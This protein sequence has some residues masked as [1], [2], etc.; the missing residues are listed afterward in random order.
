[1]SEP[2]KV[3]AKPEAE[4]HYCNCCGKS[5]KLVKCGRCKTTYYCD[6][7]CQKKDWTLH[8]PRCIPPEKKPQKPAEQVVVDF[9]ECATFE[10]CQVHLVKH[11]ALINQEI[12]DEV[13]FLLEK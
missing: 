13:L 11:P 7:E 12:A 9:V 6:V 10:Q 3:E 8:K 5:G 2:T 1:M 4:E